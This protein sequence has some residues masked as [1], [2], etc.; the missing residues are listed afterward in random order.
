MRRFFRVLFG[1]VLRI[2]FSEIRIEGEER[3][4]RTGPVMFV[5]N[6]PNALIDPGVILCLAPR[7]V[8]F[9]AKSTLFKMPVVGWIVRGFDSIP[10][11]RRDDVAEGADPSQNRKTFE[12][13]RNLL[14]GGG[15]LAMFPEGASHSDA[16]MRRFKSGA[17]RLAL[18]ASSM[19]E[20]GAE[21]FRIVP[22]G[23]YYTDK[24][25][26]RS[27]ILLIYSE[28]LVVDPVELDASFE[29]PADVVNAL[30]AR[31]RTELEAVTL[32]AE[33]HEALGLIERTERIFSAAGERELSLTQVFERRRQFLAGYQRLKTTHPALME[34]L[35]DRVDRY[36]ARVEALGLEVEHIRPES[37]S[38][39]NV[40]TYA[41]RSLALVVLLGP[42][43]VVGTLLHWPAYVTVRKVATRVARGEEDTLSTIKLLAAMLF[44]ILTWLA[45][46][47]VVLAFST[48]P[49][50]LGGLALAP[51]SGYVALRFQERFER[52]IEA[53]RGLYVFVTRRHEYERLHQERV[54]IRAQILALQ[55]LME[56]AS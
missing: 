40:L 44:F 6:H 49:W 8:S 25:T 30:T 39:R 4:P 19:Q 32:Q 31:L 21:P 56:E 26:F 37:Y 50:A 10:V 16:S 17:A 34:A 41:T 2:F 55:D 45:T 38:P 20:A 23:L 48:W 3:I 51:L 46:A 27:S 35:A 52:I 5:L 14:A 9:M 36:V 24:K 18:G 47:G 42:L 11:N 1:F 43:A 29:P 33:H 28:P 15:A 54:Q 13:C 22:A 7:P 53:A 12:Q